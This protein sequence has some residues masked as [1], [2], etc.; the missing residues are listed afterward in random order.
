VPCFKQSGTNKKQEIDIDQSVGR[1]LQTSLTERCPL[2]SRLLQRSGGTEVSSQ[3]LTGVLD[4]LMFLLIQRFEE[5]G[6]EFYLC[7]L[8]G[9]FDGTFGM[10]FVSSGM[11]KGR[12]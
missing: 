5:G 11:E 3:V 4:G 8:T 2:C 10:Q 1:W 9:T 7:V 12:G 6:A